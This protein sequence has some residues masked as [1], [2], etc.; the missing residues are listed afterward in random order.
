MK[1]VPTYSLYG[2]NSNEP[3]L[4]QLHFESIPERSGINDWEI[5]PHRHE[6]FFQVLYVHQG[7]GRALLD[8]REYPLGS[9]TVVTVPPRCVHG[10]R[11]YA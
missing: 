1:T 8:D 10:F 7:S 5:K 3:L 9:R 2:V 6:R 11:F 4:E